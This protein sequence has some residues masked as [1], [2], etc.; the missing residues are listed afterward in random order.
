MRT[1]AYRGRLRHVRAGIYH[2]A[3][4]VGCCWSLM[5][6]LIALGVMDL[7]WMA[8][9][10][11]V[12]TLEKLWRYGRH[13][14]LAVGVGAD[15]ARPRSPRR[16]PASSPGFTPRRCRCRWSRCDT[17]GSRAH[18]SRCATATRS[19][20]AGGSTASRAAGRPTASAP[21]PSP[22]RSSTGRSAAS[23]SRTCAWCSPSGTATTSR[24]RRGRGCSTSTSAPTSR[25]GPCS[26]TS[27]R[28]GW[29]AR[30]SASSPG[31]SSRA[32]CS[33]SSRAGSRSTTRPAADGS[34]PARA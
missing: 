24:D 12:I 18:T 5:L 21:A 17:G 29:A 13:V 31:R 15:R 14:A 8:A 9:F 23:T 4:C 20:R 10:A 27:S 34:G 22:G 33:R 3:Y 7:R 1:G 28:V 6:A 16:T 11:V 26:R 30:R 25:G 19:A 2:G 32:T